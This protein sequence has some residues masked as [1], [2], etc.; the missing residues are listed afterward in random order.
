MVREEAAE[1][2]ELLGTRLVLVMTAICMTVVAYNTTAVVTILPNLKSGF[3]LTPTELQWVMAVYTVTG[4]TFVPILGRLGDIVGKM[5][6]F[7]FGMACF[8]A[9]SLAVVVAPD[10]AILLAGRAA[11]GAGAAAL[12]GTSLSLLNAATPEERRASVT[13]IWGAMIGL[14]MSLGPI[15]G[16][17]F[18]DYLN[19]RGVFISDLVLLAIAFVLGLRV[20]R[21]GYVPE[22]RKPD[23]KFDTAGAVALVLLLGPLSFALSNGDRSGW[24][25]PLTLLPLALAAVAACA[26]ALTARRLDDPLIEWRYFRHPRYLMATLGM[27]FSGI[28]FFCLFIYFNL[29]AQSAAALE[30]SAVQAGAAILPLSVM[31]F[32]VSTS[33]PRV[34]AP[35]SFRW[36]LTIGMAC[37]ALG[38]LL[39][40]VT[41]NTTGY[42]EIWWKLVIIGA[43][44][45]LSF[46]LLPR[47]GLRLLP[48][49]HAGQGS[50]VI[51]TCLYFGATL[52][53]VLGGVVTAMTVRSGLREVIAALPAGSTQSEGLSRALAHG[54]PSQVQQLLAGLEPAT[55][56][57]L[58]AALRDLQDNAFDNAMMVGAAGALIGLVLALLLLRGPV[59]PL[60]SAAALTQGD[61]P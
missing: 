18:A 46:S 10:G 31:M 33:A 29:F 45:G 37:L 44:M 22:R 34:L 56:T 55:S 6:V 25:S 36:P 8:S 53:S 1:P 12:F 39:L 57:A 21:R 26:L 17:T 38:F 14:G 3:D 13:G 58:S 50:G 51:N 52:G 47:V 43:G 28:S 30:L 60:R 23:A 27:F 41:S 20:A 61:A 9:G 11:Q 19:W 54:T 35:V 24:T 4:A 40:S 16:G 7:F 59:P 49:E 5:K 15:V 42:S 48:E 2:S 32:I